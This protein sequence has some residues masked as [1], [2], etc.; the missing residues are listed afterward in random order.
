MCPNSAIGPNDPC[1]CGSG[2]KYKRCC[3]LAVAPA[4]SKWKRFAFGGLLALGF[5]VVVFGP[6][7]QRETAPSAGRGIGLGTR[8]S[9]RPLGP[10]PAGKV[11]SVEHGHWH[12]VRNPLSGPGARPPAQSFTPAPQPGGPVPPGKV[13]SVEHGHWH[14]DPNAQS[15]ST[16]ATVDAPPVTIDFSPKP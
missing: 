3:G 8:P 15:G 9:A 10:A 7:F 13:W 14:D 12:D 11:W 2:K 5:G 16:P 6:M 4:R 1:P